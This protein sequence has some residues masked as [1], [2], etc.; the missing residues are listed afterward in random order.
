M[1]IPREEERFD[2]SSISCGIFF[3]LCRFTHLTN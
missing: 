1:L 3:S 2:F